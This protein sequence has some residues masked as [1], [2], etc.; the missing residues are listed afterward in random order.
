MS[1]AGALYAYYLSNASQDTYTLALVIG[2]YAMIIIGGLGSL[3]GSVF[4]AL[5][6]SFLPAVLTSLSTTIGPNAPVIGNLLANHE[7]DVKLDRVRSDRSS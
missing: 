3:R 2:Y 1:A 5:L 6:Y 4:G 7:A